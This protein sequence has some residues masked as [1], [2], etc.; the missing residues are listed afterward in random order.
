MEK[1]FIFILYFI[2]K[3]LTIAN[4]YFFD[5]LYVKLIYLFT[6]QYNLGKKILYEK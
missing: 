5:N 4:Y 2:D 1:S 6:K 3:H